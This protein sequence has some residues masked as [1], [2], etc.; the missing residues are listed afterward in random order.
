MP[1]CNDSFNI[2][3]SSGD[4]L[5]ANVFKGKPSGEGSS[6]PEDVPGSVTGMF[7]DLKKLR[8]ITRAL[9]SI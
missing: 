4:N 9:R 7:K 6:H 8:P 3:S 2:F 5:S 1:D